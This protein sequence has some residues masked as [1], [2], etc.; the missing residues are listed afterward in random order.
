MERRETDK[1]PTPRF[2]PQVTAAPGLWFRITLGTQNQVLVSH[3]GGGSLTLSHHCTSQDLHYQD[4]GVKGKEELEPG[5]PTW[6][7]VA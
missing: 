1:T 5:T 2:T 7:V 4:A 3:V 6:D